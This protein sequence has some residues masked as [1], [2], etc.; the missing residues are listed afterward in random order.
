MRLA[1]GT[2]QLGLTYGINNTSGVPAN[3][4][5]KK[6]FSVAGAAGI[7][8]IDTAIAYGD[9]EQKIGLYSDGKFKIITKLPAFPERE[10]SS[11]WLADTIDESLKRLQ[12]ARLHGLLLHRPSQLRGKEGEKLLKDLQQLKLEG[13]VDNIGISIYEPSELDRIENID[14]IDIVQAPFNILD[15]R[16]FETGWLSKLAKAGIEVHARSVF[17]QGL[18]L[19]EPS[20]R[21]PKFDPWNSLLSKY[22][23]WL[24]ISGLTPLQACLR[25]VL[26]FKEISNV[27]VGIDNA[28]HLSEI[29]TASKGDIPIMPD[30]IRSND[31][32]LINPLSWLDF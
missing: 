17:L 9:A 7:N 8:V 32:K 30:D 25:F 10:Y 5:I 2:V 28:S 4:E 6:I 12:T 13:K 21:L 29:I 31:V 24:Q 20:K 19:V 1:L 3:E 26:A 22:D 27:V 23:H 18:L 11:A 15:R 16:L 14:E